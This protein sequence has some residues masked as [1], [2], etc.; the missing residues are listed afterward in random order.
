MTLHAT[1]VVCVYIDM[2]V[3]L[4]MVGDGDRNIQYIVK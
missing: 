1:C 4:L 2:R 3:V